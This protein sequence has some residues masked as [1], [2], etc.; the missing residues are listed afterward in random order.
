[1]NKTWE[2]LRGERLYELGLQLLG[3]E[4]HMMNLV[5]R[6][7]R[8]T[9]EE[10]LPQML[11]GKRAILKEVIGLLDLEDL[12]KVEEVVAPICALAGGK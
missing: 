7:D 4:D 10:E 8:E 3:A 1:M 5:K 6:G 11:Y 12:H 9:Y 2:E